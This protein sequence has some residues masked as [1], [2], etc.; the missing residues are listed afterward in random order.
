MNV[1]RSPFDSP[2]LRELRVTTFCLFGMIGKIPFQ[3]R[4]SSGLP[5]RSLHEIWTLLS[6]PEVPFAKSGLFRASRKVPLRILELSGRSGEA[7]TEIRAVLGRPEGPFTRKW[8]L[9]GRPELPLQR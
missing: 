7:L 5:E 1:A 8:G 9:P 4:A 2:T 6:S 3:N